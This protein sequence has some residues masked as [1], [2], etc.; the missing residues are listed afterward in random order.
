MEDYQRSSYTV[1]DCKCHLVWS[2][3]YR[4]DVLASDVGLRCRDLIR[5][6]AQAHDLQIYS[7]VVN[8][9]HV[10]LLVGIPPSLSVSTAVQFLKGNSSHKLLNEY[11]S[12]RR[13]YWG[14]HLWAGACWVASSGNVTV[15][16]WMEYIKNQKP[17]E[18]DDNFTV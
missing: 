1:W 15:E 6:I 13:R 17:P 2:T 8:K 16:E 12:V 11:K 14:K 10:H 4:Y 18:P 5:A 9:D 7:G 3:K